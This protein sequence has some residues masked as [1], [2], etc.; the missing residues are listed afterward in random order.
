MLP[1][2]TVFPFCFYGRGY[3]VGSVNMDKKLYWYKCSKM[4]TRY[5]VECM[6]RIGSSCIGWCRSLCFVIII[7]IARLSLSPALAR[8]VVFKFIT[9][10]CCNSQNYPNMFIQDYKILMEFS[11][12]PQNCKLHLCPPPHQC[13][14]ILAPQNP[15]IPIEFKKRFCFLAQFPNLKPIVMS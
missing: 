3:K 7:E 15:Y 12:S 9:V 11:K 5:V 6:I 8:C 14:E 10:T 13:T 1:N 4:I 2:V